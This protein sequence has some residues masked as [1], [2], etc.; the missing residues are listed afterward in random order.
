MVGFAGVDPPVELRSL[1]REFDLGGVV[2]FKRNIEAP[3]QVV[4]LVHGLRQMGTSEPPWVAVDQEG[5]RVARLRTPFTE[6]PPM[7]TLGRRGEVT[8]AERFGRALAEELRLVGVSFD[9]APVLDVNTNA[10]NPVIGDRALGDT[11]EQVAELGKAIIGSLQSGGVAACGKHFPG[12][13]DSAVDP[14][15]SLPLIDH[16]PD[17]FRAVE[18]APFRAAIQSDVASVMTAHVVVPSLDEDRPA[19]LSPR[20]VRDLL[21]EE[22]GFRGLIISDDLEMGAL[23]GR[24]LE[25]STLLAIEA[26]SDVVLLC[27]SNPDRQ[28]A[29]LETL[30]RAFES[31]RLAF[32]QLDDALVRHRRARDRFAR[33][34]I[35]WRPPSSRALRSLLGSDKHQAIA[36]EMRR[37]A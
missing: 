18:F 17:R 9:F 20:I 11:P 37:E 19:S 10:S 6:W 28:A 34:L 15:L 1:A 30:V 32:K 26:G 16:P 36:D 3:G 24:T 4:D 27:G 5:G 33:T 25:E 13:G 23:S 35:E 14:H 21:R 22:L 7:A 29:A 31:G 8:L 12:L 2:L